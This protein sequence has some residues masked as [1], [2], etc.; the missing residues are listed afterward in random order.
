MGSITAIMAVAYRLFTAA[1]SKNWDTTGKEEVVQTIKDL[2]AEDSDDP[3]ISRPGKEKDLTRCLYEFIWAIV[4]GDLRREQG[5]PLLSEILTWHPDMASQ[6]V[7]IATIIDLETTNMDRSAR[8]REGLLV[9]LKSLELDKLLKERLEIETIGDAGIVKNKKNFH[10]KQIKVETKLF[11]K[12][13]KF[14]L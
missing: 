6:V 10:T 2:L 11:Y 4:K 8:Q 13:Q 3:G 9:I 5:K 7:E 1:T 14:N 12:Q